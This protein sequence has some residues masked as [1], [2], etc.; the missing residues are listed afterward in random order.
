MEVME[1]KSLSP[2]GLLSG[3]T[4]GSGLI[5]S[6]GLRPDQGVDVWHVFK[7]YFQ[8]R[9]KKKK[10]VKWQKLNKL[11]NDFLLSVWS[12]WSDSNRTSHYFFNLIEA[13]K[14]IV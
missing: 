11:E 5:G 7:I 3:L 12:N 14:H 4:P 13:Y 1:K 6:T 2:A 9:I 10:A 8:K